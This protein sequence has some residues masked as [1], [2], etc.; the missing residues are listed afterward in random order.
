[1]S[2]ILVSGLINIETTLRIDGFPLHYNPVNYP[3]LG[4]N[5]TVSGVGYNLAKALT[6]LGNQVNFVSLIGQDMAAKLVKEA[7]ATDHIAN[8][9]V[10]DAI[11][12]T[13]QSVILYDKTGKR[14]IH[15]DLK[16]IQEQP[17]PESI[18]EQAMADCDLLAL[19]NIN[20]SRP[21]L[22][23][24]R[25]A[26]KL[27]ATDVHTIG[28]LDDNYNRDF[29]QAAN[30]LFM[31]DE[32]L[33]MSP[34]DWAKLVLKR[35]APDILVIGLGSQGVL[36]TVKQDNFSERIAAVQTRP[37][38]NT[39]G[40]GDAL[41]SAFIHGYLATKNPYTAIKKAI[42]FASYK[43]GAASAADGFLDAE[44]LEL[45]HSKGRSFI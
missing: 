38:V 24:G 17:Y 16:N 5:S 23:K 7:L 6:V 21:F 20:F 30:I 40:A 29:M 35:Y 8:R 3:F 1:M 39:I 32:A 36:L 45:I 28:D 31:S 11:P 33:P 9:F 42:T 25:K 41:F 37:I 4:V 43:I 34:E 13:A 2:N 44:S 26:G 19:C 27:I 12:Q 18:F 14:Q 22:S 15:V 10:L